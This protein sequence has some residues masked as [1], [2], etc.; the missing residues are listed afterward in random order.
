MQVIV[1]D[2]QQG[3]T[4]RLVEWVNQGRKV[5][6]Y[7]GWSRIIVTVDKRRAVQMCKKYSLP[8]DRVFSYTEYREHFRGRKIYRDLEIGVD[9]LDTIVA[10]Q[11]SYA[12]QGRVVAATMHAQRVNRFYNN[13]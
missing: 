7:P 4:T 6:D 11:F 12:G 5:N 2:R 1:G 9:D 10:N 8:S 13:D 3:K